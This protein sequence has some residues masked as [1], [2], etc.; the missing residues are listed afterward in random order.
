MTY[1]YFTAWSNS[2]PAAAVYR[3][4]TA[5]GNVQMVCIN[6][7]EMERAV[8]D[9]RTDVPGFWES[10]PESPVTRT[11]DTIT[12]VTAEDAERINRMHGKVVVPVA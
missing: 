12:P 3:L 11:P 4:D 6:Y 1:I 2:A 9:G 8:A 10:L 5:T 7:A